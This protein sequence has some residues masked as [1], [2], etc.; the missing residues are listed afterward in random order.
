MEPN[1]ARKARSNVAIGAMIRTLQNVAL[2]VEHRGLVLKREHAAMMRKVVISLTGRSAVQMA[3]VQQRRT[4]VERS[5][6]QGDRHAETISIA[7]I[8]LQQQGRLLPALEHA[9][10]QH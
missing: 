7:H 8:L 6:A 3:P 4:V 1:A 5:V 9:P 2:L 10:H